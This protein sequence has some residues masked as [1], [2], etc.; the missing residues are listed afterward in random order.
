MSEWKPIKSAPRDRWI[1][2]T[3][4]DQDHPA[5]VA[6]WVLKA[7]GDDYFM[8]AMLNKTRLFVTSK[9]VTHWH[10]LPELPHDSQC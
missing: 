8:W 5:L 2:V 6:K 3:A 4:P 9:E 1:L 10:E 7:N